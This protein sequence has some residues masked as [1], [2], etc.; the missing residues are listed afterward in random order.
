VSKAVAGVSGT[1]IVL[2]LAGGLTLLVR[3]RQPTHA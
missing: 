3:R 1:V 2:V